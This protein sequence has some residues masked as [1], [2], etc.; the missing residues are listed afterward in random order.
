MSFPRK[1]IVDAIRARY[2]KGTCMELVSMDDPHSKL[3][4]G[5]RGVVDRVD[6]IAEAD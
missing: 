6:D 3:K 4:P 2:P 5:A 1:E